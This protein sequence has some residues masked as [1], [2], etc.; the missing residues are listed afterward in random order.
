[1]PAVLFH[2]EGSICRERPTG[3][4]ARRVVSAARAPLRSADGPT[5][6]ALSAMVGNIL[7]STLLRA[8]WGKFVDYPE[9]LW[10]PYKM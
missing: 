8:L 9:T 5:L 10:D 2:V 6:S 7:R 4:A 3:P 1:V